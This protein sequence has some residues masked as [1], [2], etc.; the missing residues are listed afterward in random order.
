MIS[1][2]L[3]V[4]NKNIPKKRLWSTYTLTCMCVFKIV[5]NAKLTLYLINTN[6]IL[7][8]T[9]LPFVTF[10]TKSPLDFHSTNESNF[11]FYTS[12]RWHK[13]PQQT[14]LGQKFI[15]ADLSGIT[16]RWKARAQ[17]SAAERR[18][19]HFTDFQPRLSS[20]RDENRYINNCFIWSTFCK[21]RK[22]AK[23]QVI[24]MF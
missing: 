7:T 22:A 21:F 9:F 19:F 5:L 23:V 16:A 8:N 10:K 20:L 11:S 1:V 4:H 6:Q 2:S 18:A 15:T 3:D 17:F 24:G 13:E 14:N 12:N